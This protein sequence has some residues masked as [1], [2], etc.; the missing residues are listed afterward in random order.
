MGL[1]GCPRSPLPVP[2]VAAAG[3]CA[4][5]ILLPRTSSMSPRCH[6]AFSKTHQCCLQYGAY[7]AFCDDMDNVCHTL[8]CSV[9]TTCHSKLDAAV[10][11]ARCGENKWCLNGECVPV[12]FRPEAVDCGWSGWSAWSICS[13]SCG[14]GVQSAE[15]GCT[16]PA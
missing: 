2:S 15:W 16:Q 5:M 11:G 7:S 3:A 9:G 10:D 8:W 6:P 13:R 12:G 1:T 4:W 14:V